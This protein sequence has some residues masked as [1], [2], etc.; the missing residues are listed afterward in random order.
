MRICAPKIHE[1]HTRARAATSSTRSSSMSA[2]VSFARRWH[3]D[4]RQASLEIIRCH[5]GA[6]LSDAYRVHTSLAVGTRGG[7]RCGMNLVPE[8]VPFSESNK[9][10]ICS[11][12]FG[13]GRNG[14]PTI[15]GI[16]YGCHSS[17]DRGVK[18]GSISR[19]F[20]YRA[21]T[22]L[23]AVLRTKRDCPRCGLSGGLLRAT[24]R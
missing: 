20:L 11:D 21:R 10:R 3:H 5:N 7:S 24:S 8:G 4:A 16:S 9:R 15:R 23:V 2:A 17:R 6:Q 1:W 12:A 18:N 14:Y 13:P 22:T 19:R